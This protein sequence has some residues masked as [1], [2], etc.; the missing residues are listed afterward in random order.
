MRKV[1]GRRDREREKTE[2]KGRT[3]M[4][5]KR[6]GVFRTKRNG[7]QR[8]CTKRVE[9]GGESAPGQRREMRLKENVGRGEL[10]RR[11]LEVAKKVRC[12]RNE[13]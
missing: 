6:N 11:R 4:E 10:R 7:Q 8:G 9:E 13:S 5:G 3:A 1:D 12:R 2:G